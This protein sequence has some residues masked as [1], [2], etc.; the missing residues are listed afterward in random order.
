[1]EFRFLFNLEM[2][3]YFYL[4]HVFRLVATIHHYKTAF[5]VL[6]FYFSALS[7][8]EKCLSMF[9]KNRSF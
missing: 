5:C 2:I 9:S 8:I 1:M 3:Q 7:R 4:P 6:W